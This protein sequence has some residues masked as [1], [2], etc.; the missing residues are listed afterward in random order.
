MKFIKV[1]KR[2]PRRHSHYWWA[3]K[4]TVYTVGGNLTFEQEVARWEPIVTDRTYI[5]EGLKEL[6]KAGRPSEGRNERHWLPPLNIGGRPAHFEA[7]A[8]DD[9]RAA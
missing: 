3:L 6:E 9:L 1:S 2:L 4:I 7:F 8:R 5:R